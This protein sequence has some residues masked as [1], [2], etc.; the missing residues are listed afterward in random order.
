MAVVLSQG[1]FLDDYSQ[2]LLDVPLGPAANLLD[3]LTDE[4]KNWMQEQFHGAKSAM[5]QRFLQTYG[6]WKDLP[7]SI[8]S[9]GLPLFYN[10][11]TMPESVLQ[12]TLQAAR[13]QAN[14]CMQ[15]W[16]RGRARDRNLTQMAKQFLDPRRKSNFRT[17]LEEFTAGGRMQDSLAK[18]CIS[19]TS[20]LTSMQQLEA[21]HRYLAQHVGKGRAALP[22]STCAFLRRRTNSDLFQDQFRKR[23]DKYLSK[24]GSIITMTEWNSR[25]AIW[26]DVIVCIFVS[27]AVFC[28]RFRGV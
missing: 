1:V 13:S 3:S 2:A 23:V 28:F 12:A 15:R 22:A 19:Y 24:T 10:S 6:F 14:A 17:S 7:W 11:D 4:D 25:S 20:A 5:C 18:A 9:I 16:D 8:C 27:L 26:N 21:Q